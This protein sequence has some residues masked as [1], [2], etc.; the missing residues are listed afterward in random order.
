MKISV[1]APATTANLG[2]GFDCAAVALD[3]WNEVVITD[4]GTPDRTHLGV[5][6]F[7][8][9]DPADGLRFEFFDRIP[10]ERG[11]GSSA[12]V[13][14]LGLVAAA[15]VADRA[16]DPEW[17]LREGLPLEGHA[18]NL[19]AALA[20]GACLSVGG[21][22]H[23]VADSV[24]AVPI[25]LVPDTT[26]ATAE[27]RAPRPEE[28]PLGD[29]VLSG[30]RAA[31]RGAGLASASEDVFA[32]ELN[33]RLHEP[34]RAANAPLLAEV[35]DDLPQGALGA[36]ISGSG[37]TVIVWADPDRAQECSVELSTRFPDV[38]VLWLSTSAKG[39]EL[40]S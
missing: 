12:A 16:P 26:V 11:L 17:L 2:A 23:R 5:R 29:A 22:I 28:I 33:D 27:A 14:A 7:E 3:L 40:V 21:R 38:E 31:H 9:I 34:H 4:G 24:P 37:P 19:A 39:A 15:H 35:R 13:I 20:G 32:A 25:A 1:R 36:T 10:R 6:A 8:R 18:D 30:G